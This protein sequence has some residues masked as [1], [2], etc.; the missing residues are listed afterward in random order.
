MKVVKEG[1]VEVP[2]H[3]GLIAIIYR[4]IPCANPKAGPG[5]TTV[6]E[7]PHEGGSVVE[8]QK[9]VEHTEED[10]KS[11]QL[12]SRAERAAKWAKAKEM[13]KTLMVKKKRTQ[14]QDKLK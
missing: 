12:E 11:K 8:K 9:P 14:R 6:K 13:G 3:Q 10:R 7:E 5:I 4:A 1:N 2:M